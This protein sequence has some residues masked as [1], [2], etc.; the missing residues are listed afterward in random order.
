MGFQL[1][2]KRFPRN[3]WWS[4]LLGLGVTFLAA[5]AARYSV[6]ARFLLPY[7]IDDPFAPLF[8][9]I[10][11]SF[12]ILI[13]IVTISVFRKRDDDPPPALPV[14]VLNLQA[15]GGLVVFVLSA[16][17]WHHYSFP[18]EESAPVVFGLAF[19][20]QVLAYFARTKLTR[21]KPRR[22]R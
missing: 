18:A 19:V 10:R 4:T 3:L 6:R 9:I 16:A 11:N 13:I 21:S 1:V 14:F 20:G 7:G 8:A 17:L 5:F 15:L 22:V 12:W 2:K